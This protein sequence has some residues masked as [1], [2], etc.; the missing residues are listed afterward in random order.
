MAPFKWALATIL[1]TK[2]LGRARCVW[3]G[4]FF[5]SIGAVNLSAHTLPPTKIDVVFE[6]ELLQV[7]IPL[8]I[9]E[10]IAD[11]AAQLADKTDAMAIADLFDQL[12]ISPPQ[13]VIDAFAPYSD[14]FIHDFKILGG[15]QEFQLTITAIDIPPANADGAPRET[16]IHAETIIPQNIAAVQIGWGAENGDLVIITAD[17]SAVDYLIGGELSQPI[18]R[19]AAKAA[20]F[21]PGHYVKIGFIHILPGGADHILFVLGLFFFGLGWRRLVTQATVFTLAHSLTLALAAQGLVRISSGIVEPLIALSIIFVALEN[22]TR[23]QAALSWRR[24]AVIFGFGLVHGLGFAGVL[25]DLGAHNGH[26]FT[27][28]VFF[29]LGV[30]LGQIAILALAMVFVGLPF[31]RRQHYRR[32]IADPASVAIGAVGLYWFVIRLL[33]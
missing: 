6:G 27:Q 30:E 9:E 21:S 31:G 3:L 17:A 5:V 18:L 19:E 13:N 7:A 15:D 24:L 12:T 8:V 22:L 10:L 4:L 29:N 23:H 16:V 1:R 2:A 20:P 25:L 14:A 32:Y 28:I 33:G 11:M 26:I